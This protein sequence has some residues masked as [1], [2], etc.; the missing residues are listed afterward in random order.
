MTQQQNETNDDA[1]KR[2]RERGQRETKRREKRERGGRKESRREGGGEEREAGQEGPG[3]VA[4]ENGKDDSLISATLPLG[5]CS[6][7]RPE[8]EIKE[9]VLRV[10][11]WSG[12]G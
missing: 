4:R 8:P 6:T 5:V 2:E 9:P 11:V 12:N 1:R 7:S 3:R 10:S